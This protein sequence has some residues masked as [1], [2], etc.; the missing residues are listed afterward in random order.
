MS[1]ILTIKEFKII[2]LE[3]IIDTRQFVF[4]FLNMFY[5]VVGIDIQACPLAVIKND[6]KILK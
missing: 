5:I 4:F 3:E 2:I 6:P 1:L